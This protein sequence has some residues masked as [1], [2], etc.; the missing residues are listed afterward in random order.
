MR[1]ATLLLLLSVQLACGSLI[2]GFA[3]QIIQ[4]GEDGY[5]AKR[6]PWEGR[7][8]ANSFPRILVTPANNADVILAMRYANANGWAVTPRNG[9]HSYVGGSTT[10]GVLL[11][12]SSLN[13][14]TVNAGEM[15]ADIGAGQNMLGVYHELYQQGV[16]FPGGGCPSV[17]FSGLLLGGGFGM[18]SSSWGVASD[19]V[20][21]ATVIVTDTDAS[22]PNRSAFR[23]VRAVHR[24][25]MR[26]LP[27]YNLGS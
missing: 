8:Q 19:S 13:Q 15:T 27:R 21:S 17:G 12:L 9:G 16:A 23:Q 20:L 22:S 18:M 2:P 24:V 1:H 4:P 5:E 3:G 11:D 10:S 26:R 6:K 7:F 25:P 14:T